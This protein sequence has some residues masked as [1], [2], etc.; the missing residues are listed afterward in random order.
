MQPDDALDDTRD[1]RRAGSV[2]VE[3]NAP[4]GTARR[5]SCVDWLSDRGASS[6]ADLGCGHGRLLV[7]MAQAQPDLRGTGVDMD[8]VAIADARSHAGVLGVDQRV[9]FE[10]GDAA[11]WSG[12]ADAVV[13]IGVSHVFGG[14]ARMLS[15]LTGLVTPQE[16]GVALIGASVWAARPDRWA[17]ETFGE[18]LRP[19]DMVDQAEAEG[20]TV[21][22]LDLSTMQEWDDFE[23]T[24][25][26]GVEAVGTPQ[27]LAF[28][29]ER[30]KESKRYRGT[31]GFA[32]L[33]L[34]R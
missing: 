1:L 9:A 30:R 3:V 34:V 12:E 15:H 8:E 10:V 14:T 4:M 19:D 7:Q 32:W 25:T 24:W 20:W 16:G 23:D 2:A 6:V 28:A 22:D 18:L 27:A 17:R 5:E 31:L 21:D 13:V 33:Q 11:R 26:A 29:N